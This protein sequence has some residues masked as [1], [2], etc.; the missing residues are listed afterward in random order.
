ML[1]KFAEYIYV[2]ARRVA[3]AGYGI[4]FNVSNLINVNA[5]ESDSE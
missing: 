3:R 2:L 1:Q 5:D 4:D